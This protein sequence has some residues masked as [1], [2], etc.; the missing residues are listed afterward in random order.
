MDA[1][2][3]TPF[4]CQVVFLCAWG[5]LFL[6]ARRF[7]PASVPTSPIVLSI[8]MAVLFEGLQNLFVSQS[9]SLG[10]WPAHRNMRMATLA[11]T[12]PMLMSSIIAATSVW[13]ERGNRMLATAVVGSILLLLAGADNWAF[14]I[15]LLSAGFV[16]ATLAA[17]I[18]FD[19]LRRESVLYPTHIAMTHCKEWRILVV[20]AS[21]LPVAVLQSRRAKDGVAQSGILRS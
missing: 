19:G 6:V 15:A 12:T 7:L 11:W 14:A 20:R 10:I 4:T 1:R 2:C 18:T 5:T 17:S 9:D 8:M 13:F 3:R 16:V 21:F